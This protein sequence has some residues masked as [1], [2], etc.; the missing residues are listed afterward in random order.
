MIRRI[1]R[2]MTAFNRP[3]QSS[4]DYYTNEG[5]NEYSESIHF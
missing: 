1:V 3:K 4:L 2:L 5:L